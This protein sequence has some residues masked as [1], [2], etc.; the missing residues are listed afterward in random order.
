MPPKKKPP[1]LDD[2]LEDEPVVVVKSEPVAEPPKPQ[3]PKKVAPKVKTPP[4]LSYHDND[5]GGLGSDE[6]Y[7]WSLED[8][9]SDT[10]KALEA[11]LGKGDVRKE[12][13]LTETQIVSAAL[14]LEM[15]S[16]WRHK[17]IRAIVHHFM[18]CRVSLNRG[19]RGEAVAAFT[20]LVEN[21][22]AN[23]TE[24]IANSL[25]RD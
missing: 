3:K 25:R 8:S 1:T 19:S 21:R 4:T 10:S 6:D 17:R 12:S 24:N 5:D 7:K 22:R 15:S 14:L 9:G 13:E 20:G 11:F 2:L 23:A 16:R 18:S